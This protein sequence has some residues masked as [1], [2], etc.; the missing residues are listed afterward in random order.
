MTKPM[1]E[2]SPDR[3]M[4]HTWQDS[5]RRPP[6]PPVAA[7]AFDQKSWLLT[8]RIQQLNRSV[9]VLGDM[10]HRAQGPAG[11]AARVVTLGLKGG[12]KPVDL[13]RPVPPIKAH[14]WWP[15]R[16]EPD[17]AL[18]PPPGGAHL[19]DALTTLEVLAF[20]VMGL[21]G[22]D[23]VWAVDKVAADQGG[24]RRFKPLFLTDAVDFG[25]IYRRGF[26]AEF[27]PALS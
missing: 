23:L 14:G 5:G 15:V 22:A 7:P 18:Q 3:S 11:K 4:A 6:L 12:P 26:V 25:A 27:F 19:T 21:R 24:A 9:A 8:S 17:H 2:M 16:V 20:D 1:M 10:V 13:P